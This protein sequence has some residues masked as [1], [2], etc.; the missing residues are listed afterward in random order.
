MISSNEQKAKTSSEENSHRT[1]EVITKQMDW[2]KLKIP[3][4]PTAITAKALYKE[5]PHRIPFNLNQEFDQTTYVGRFLKNFYNLNPLLYY[6]T[7][8]QIQ[9]ALDTVF[10][11]QKGLETSESP[12]GQMLMTP[13][14][15]AELKKA[16]RIVGGSVH[17]ETGEI[18][19]LPMR[20]S[21]FVSFNVPLLA[22]MLFTKNQSPAFNAIVQMVN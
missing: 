5:E 2:S 7:N 17:P 19:S 10:K 13:E 3:I 9:T 6:K 14:E 20:L 22:A 1:K 21:G 4:A 15:I 12:N 8:S 11:Y 18:I 16:S